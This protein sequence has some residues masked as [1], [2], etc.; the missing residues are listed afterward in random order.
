MQYQMLDQ[1]AEEI[2]DTIKHL[3]QVYVIPRL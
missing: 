1:G 3:S 2:L